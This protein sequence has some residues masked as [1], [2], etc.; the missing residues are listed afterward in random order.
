MPLAA[1]YQRVQVRV[2]CAKPIPNQFGVHAIDKRHRNAERL[3]FVGESHNGRVNGNRVRI[4]ERGREPYHVAIVEGLHSSVYHA[5][6]RALDQ[7]GYVK[8][9]VSWMLIH[10]LRVR[11]RR[12][13]RDCK[14]AASFLTAT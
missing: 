14:G 9:E 4:R 7:D 2:V 3:D 13:I 12:F 11:P 10:L 5:A 6:L 8:L 1:R